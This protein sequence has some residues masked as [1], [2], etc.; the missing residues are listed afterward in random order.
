MTTIVD[1]PDLVM[2]PGSAGRAFTSFED[3]SR[4]YRETII[5]LDLGASQTPHCEL[6][7]A[8]ESWGHISYNGRVWQ[9]TVNGAV[10][11]Y[12]PRA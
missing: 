11:V 8:G 12:D 4:A 3:V 10:C 7:K 9:D 5:A 6:L 1:T 2:I